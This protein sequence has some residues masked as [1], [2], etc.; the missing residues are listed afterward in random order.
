MLVGA[1]VALLGALVALHLAARRRA[2][3]EPSLGEDMQRAV[4]RGTAQ[5]LP[6]IS[7]QG[8]NVTGATLELLADAGM[9]SLTFNG[10]ASRSGISTATLERYWGSRVDAVVD[11]IHQLF[12]DRPIPDTGDLR[13]DLGAYLRAEG[14]MLSSPRVRAVIGTLI[15]EG[16]KDEA[17]AEA[18]RQRVVRPLQDK[19][20]N[21]IQAGVVAGDLPADTDV[22]IAADMLDGPLYFRALISGDPADGSIVEP[23]LQL[24]SGPST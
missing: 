8:R 2:P 4:V 7:A 19:L 18:L 15:T 20:R 10:I 23:A 22:S 13:A 1:G 11:A 17:L 21:R 3:A 5:S 16:A 14:E 6:A 12:A 9:S 24:V